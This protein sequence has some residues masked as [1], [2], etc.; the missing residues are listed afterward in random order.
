MQFRQSAV[1]FY[2]SVCPCLPV[3]NRI[4]YGIIKQTKVVTPSSCLITQQK[5]LPPSLFPNS[6]K[7]ASAKSGGS[8]TRDLE[9]LSGVL[10]SGK[11]ESVQHKEIGEIVVDAG[12]TGKSGY[13][14]K[15]IIE[16]RYKKDDK[17]AEEIAAL[18]PL[19]LDAAKNG[20][21]INDVTRVINGY[22]V[23]TVSLERNGVVAFISKKRGFADEKFIITGFD[24]AEKKQEAT[25][26][27][28]TVIASH[29]YAPDFVNVKKQVGAVI[30]SLKE[31]VPK[32]SKNARGNLKHGN[33]FLPYI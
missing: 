13:G 5:L 7:N 6:S 8:V 26:A 21:V 10:E 28:K 18:M 25:D 14:L 11:N 4:S 12:S 2:T 15:H 20:K 29:S 9:L 19:V 16:Q 33:Q 17:S 22:E 27:I 1:D 32:S 31:S 23:G 30:A 24:N 3:Y